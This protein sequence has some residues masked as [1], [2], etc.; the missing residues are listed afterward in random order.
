MKQVIRKYNIRMIEQ[1]H[2]MQFTPV[3]V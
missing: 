3:L 1:D 2:S